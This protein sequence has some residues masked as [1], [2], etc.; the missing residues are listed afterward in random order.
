GSPAGCRGYLS[1]LFMLVAQSR[2]IGD[3][4]LD[5]LRRQYRL[6][7][8][9]GSDAGETIDAVVG[10]H[11][12]VR[13]EAARIDNPQP[14]L[15]LRP[16]RSGSR[17]VRRQCALELLLREGAGVAEKAEAHLSI[18]DNAATAFRVAI[19]AGQ[20]CWNG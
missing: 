10:R 8:K 16:A 19:G 11:D 12:R 4:V 14:Q 18:N 9:G 13:V 5:L 7:L 2:E 15:A 17:Q 1:S 20:R 3:H 6:S